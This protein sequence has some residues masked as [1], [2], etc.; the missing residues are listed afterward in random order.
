MKARNDA[1]MIYKAAV[2]AVQPHRLLPK[3]IQIIDNDIYIAGRPIR[4][5]KK[6]DIYVIGAGKAAGAMA[7]VTEKILGKHIRS[8]FIVTKYKH[9]LPLQHIRIMEAAHP[10]PDENS[11]LASERTKDI[12]QKTTDSDIIICLLSGGASSLLESIP[13]SISLQDLKLLSLQLLNSG[14]SIAEMNIIRKHISTIKGGQLLKYAPTSK[15]ISL[16]I[17]DVPGDNPDVIAGGLTA[18]DASTFNDAIQIIGKYQLQHK[19]PHSVFNYLENG[20]KGLIPETIKQDD[21]ILKN[22]QNIIIGSNME[23]LREAATKATELGYHTEILD[24]KLQEDGAT[25][26]RD[27]INICRNYNGPS[28]ACLLMGGETTVAV[29]GNGKGGRNQHFALAALLEMLKDS[30]QN[31]NDV[32]VLS[33]GTDGTDGPTDAAGAIVDKNTIDAVIKYKYDPQKY[34]DNNDSYHF[35]QQAGG[36][37]KTGATQTNVMDI[38]I[39]IIR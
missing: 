16:I 36:L 3:Y 29:T 26:S 1:I 23:S 4:L 35:F 28:P 37:I 30:Y 15:W 24:N 31:K 2:E 21:R 14:A 39:A 19:I 18:A 13:E 34:F 20:R 33:A 17:S 10:V 6:Q 5:N 27:F 7:Q 9:A 32:T 25:A 22:V 38:M 11:L 8:G 12:L